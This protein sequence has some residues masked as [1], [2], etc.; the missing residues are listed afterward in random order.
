MT[1]MDPTEIPLRVF[2]RALSEPRIV[3][4]ARKLSLSTYDVLGRMNHLWM[5][6]YQQRS[7]FVSLVD[8]VIITGELPGFVEALVEVRLAD[9][10]DDLTIRVRGAE[11]AIS[12]IQA[13][14]ERLERFRDLQSERGRKSAAARRSRMLDKLQN[15]TTV[16]TTLEPRFEPGLNQDLDLQR[17]S[18]EDPDL[19]LRKITEKNNQSP[20]LRGSPS[21]GQTS[22]HSQNGAGARGW[23]DSHVGGNGGSK[24]QPGASQDGFQ[25]DRKVAPEPAQRLARILLELVIGNNPAGRLARSAARLKADTIARWALSIDKL[26]RIDA[27]TW[28]EI[29][30]MIKWCQADPF[31]SRNILGA[32]NLRDK[33]DVMNVQRNAKVARSGPRSQRQPGPTELAMRDVEELQR[34]GAP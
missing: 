34:R 9:R 15:R 19:D 5:L 3:R 20:L 29:E 31:W 4:V 32:D 33:W 25:P 28:Q 10:V 6:C 2:S 23:G 11:K 16:Q 14:E 8:A 7:E 18:P 21:S 30:V 17:S 24:T 13:E 26:N 27:M 1:T 22:D 12:D